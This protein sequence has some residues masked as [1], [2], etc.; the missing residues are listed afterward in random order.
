LQRRHRFAAFLLHLIHARFQF[1]GPAYH[2]SPEF[3]QV[4]ELG[5]SM[6][7]PGKLVE[8]GGVTLV[9][10]RHRFRCARQHQDDFPD[11]CGPLLQVPGC[12]LS[13]G[14]KVLFHLPLRITDEGEGKGFAEAFRQEHQA[15]LKILAHRRTGL[16][17]TVAHAAQHGSVRLQHDRQKFLGGRRAVLA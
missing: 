4:F 3:R 2:R 7:A 12:L 17:G 15:A 8:V 6:Q 13:P 16:D 5:K 14:L 11:I 1:L 10:L 9:A